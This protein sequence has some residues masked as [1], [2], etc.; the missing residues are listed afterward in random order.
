VN[1]H[2]AQFY[3]W[4]FYRG[5]EHQSGDPSG[6]NDGARYT[7][8]LHLL[9][10]SSSVSLLG[11]ASVV[12]MQFA[13]RPRI[14]PIISTTAVPI[15]DC[16]FNPPISTSTTSLI[17]SCLRPSYP[18]P[19]A[20]CWNSGARLLCRLRLYCAGLVY[21]SDCLADNRGEVGV[22]PDNGF[23]RSR[24]VN[25]ADPSE[26]TGT[27]LQWPSYSPAPPPNAR[28]PISTTDD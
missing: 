6:S 26:L 14:Q 16:L 11:P 28:V 24:E 8:P 7:L 10:T 15:L 12:S 19:P 25:D 3:K 27:G 9:S 4:Y 13:S 2:H 23:T 21:A 17:P 22:I 1:R 18:P 20:H 5:H